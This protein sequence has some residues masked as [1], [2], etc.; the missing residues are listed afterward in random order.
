MEKYGRA[1]D[2]L[3][4]AQLTLLEA[5]PSV[6]AQEVENE[7]ALS[8][9]EKAATPVPENTPVPKTT[10]IPV[11]GALP[12]HLERRE[13]VICC[14]EADCKCA[15]CGGETYQSYLSR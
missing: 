1:A 7:A 9:E 6:T 13:R 3:N 15:Q 12:A 2:R 4:D 5:E 10:R 8:E 11:R 14:P